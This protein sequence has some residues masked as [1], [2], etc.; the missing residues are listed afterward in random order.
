M[1]DTDVDSLL[2]VSVADLLVDDDTN[3]GSGYVVD[4]T[5]LAVVD[6]VWHLLE[7]IHISTAL[8]LSNIPEYPQ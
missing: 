4:D 1:F 6:F 3:C 5:G 7:K 2:H 8:N